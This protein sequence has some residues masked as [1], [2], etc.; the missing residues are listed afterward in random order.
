LA[1]ALESIVD[2]W[3]WWNAE[4]RD[5]FGVTDTRSAT[6]ARLHVR[7][8]Q[9]STLTPDNAM[10]TNHF[11]VVPS[12]VGDIAGNQCIVELADG[13]GLVRHLSDR[14]I[15]Y[16]QALEMAAID[17]AE[18]TP[19][20]IEAVYLAI[21]RS[22]ANRAG[23]RYL[24]IRK[25]QIDPVFESLSAAKV[26][27]TGIV[28]ASPS[29]SPFEVSRR[30]LRRIAPKAIRPRSGRNA[31]WALP[32]IAVILAIAALGQLD[33]RYYTASEA[34]DEQVQSLQ[35]RATI[36]RKRL[37]KKADEQAALAAAQGTKA[38]AVSVTKLW[39]RLTEALPQTTWL[40]EFALQN[41][42]VSIDGYS[43]DA[44][45]LIRLLDESAK[46]SGTRFT[47]PVVHTP[48][49]GGDHF[50]IQTNAAL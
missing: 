10:A 13:R 33:Y 21:E 44:A 41:T 43:G 4:L 29:A 38:Q 50:S 22:S 45:S 11:P 23:T 9:E 8:R 14:R 49:I 19:F 27:L 30:C 39:G 46:F 31:A 48:G 18:E 2:T 26:R 3:I 20:S 24:V 47:S 16:H 15:P 1:S 37:D 34:L 40:N 32:T 12:S 17:L 42:V 28:T 7:A 35:Q 25:D 6:A 36:I 5:L